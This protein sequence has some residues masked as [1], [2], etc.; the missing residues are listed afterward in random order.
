MSRRLIEAAR[1]RIRIWLGP[2]RGRSRSR[3]AIPSIVPSFATWYERIPASC[4]DGSAP[5]PGER[6]RACW[7]GVRLP[8]PCREWTATTRAMKTSAVTLTQQRSF[9]D[10]LRRW[11]GLRRLSQLELANQSGTT[12]RHLSFIEQV[13]SHPGRPIVI[14]LD[15]ALRLTLR[16]RNSLL[17][18]AGYAPA[19]G[20][21]DLD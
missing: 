3:T 10:E 9:G 2:G 7:V 20:E 15:E 12:Q 13:R 16:E 14:R 19:F 17:L 18:S 11:R 8:I 6:L 1:T 5:L 4:P 21:S